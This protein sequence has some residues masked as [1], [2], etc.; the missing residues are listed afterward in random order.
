MNK[1][2][3]VPVLFTTLLALFLLL[4]GQAFAHGELRS[5]TPGDGDHLSVAP[6]ELRLTFTEAVELALARLALTGPG[7]AVELGPLALHP[8]SATV[9]IG[10]IQAPLA[11]G[12]YAVNWQVAGADGH[13]VRGEYTFVIAPGAEG[14]APAVAGPTAPGQE[15][16]PAEHHDAVTFPTGAS[17]GA[18]SPLYAAVRWLTFLGLLGVIGVVAFRL[19][20]L[21]L[22]CRKWDP[23]GRAIVGV[24][25]SR[26]ANVGLG[27]LGLLAIALLLRLYAQSYALHGG[28][29][30]LDPGLIGTLVSRTTWG[31]GW[32]LQAAGTVVTLAGFLLA[33][34]GSRV[35]W[36]TAAVGVVM[37]AFTPGL[38]GHAAAAP[39]LAALAILA[40]ALHVLGA[41]GWLGS[42]LLVVVVGIPVALRRSDGDRGETVAALINAFSPT[43]L[44]FAGTV[45]ATGIFAAWLQLGTVPALWQS[46]Y[47]R[48]LLLK[49]AVLSV[50][51][52]TGAY[53]WLKVKPALGD[54]IAAGRLRRSAALELTVGVVVLA[55]TAVLVATATP[56]GMAPPTEQA[57]TSAPAS[58]A[59]GAAP[60][61][62][63]SAS[64]Q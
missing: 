11:A 54:E 3:R 10:A 37:L 52:G 38:S 59:S 12:T 35:G 9:L 1:T 13:P 53:N 8:D 62:S 15:P 57:S 43:A 24:A 63:S 56:Q 18:E 33:R 55:I 21:W 58:S 31:W 25:A 41:G 6:R 27:A 60:V 22:M 61:V 45:V 50:V 29:Q 40:D 46:A 64:V 4:P 44:F 49:L 36:A 48:T 23:S 32:L 28:A 30:A 39:E 2:S 34:K 19:L 26:A 47:G 14:L 51:F 42:L 16:P 17:F 20:V 5:A 7:G